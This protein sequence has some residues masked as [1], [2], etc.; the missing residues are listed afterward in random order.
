[1]ACGLG[2]D[3]I[4]QGPGPEPVNDQDL[5]ETGQS[6]IVEVVAERLE[7]LVDPGAAQIERRGD[8]LGTLQ[9]NAPDRRPAVVLASIPACTSAPPR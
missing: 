1:M 7:R 4:S 9:T 3:G 8:A 2:P 6:S 5:L